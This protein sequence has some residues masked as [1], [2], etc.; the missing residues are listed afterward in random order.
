[1]QRVALHPGR[2][3]Q[4]PSGM[5]LLF[6]CMGNICRSPVVEAVVRARFAN[7][8][9]EIDVASAGTENYHIG[10]R[11]DARAIASARAGGYDIADHRARQLQVRD[12]ADFDWLLGMDRVNMRAA[13]AQC[14]EIH[15]AKLDLFLSHAGVA[16]D[17]E[18]P[19]PYYGGSADFRRV[20]ELAEAGADGLVARLR[21]APGV[22][23][24]W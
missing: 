18:V 8:K 24:L 23:K 9:L 11:A 17:S 1:M 7:A 22:A 13:R 3:H 19:D 6:F 21:S 10:E 5:R 12:F 15:R 20:I 16:G 4:Y 14:P 2:R